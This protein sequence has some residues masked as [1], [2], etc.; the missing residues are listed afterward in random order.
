MHSYHVKFIRNGET[1][2]QVARYRVGSIV[3]AFDKCLRTFPEAKLVEGWISSS[4][5]ENGETF[6][7]KTVYA[8][9]ST[10]KIAAEPVSKASQT[11]FGFW[12]ETLSTKPNRAGDGRDSSSNSSQSKPKNKEE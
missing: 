2:P 5:K 1:K 12:P 8:P 7:G 3:G 11:H 4:Y 10:V 9:P 6:C